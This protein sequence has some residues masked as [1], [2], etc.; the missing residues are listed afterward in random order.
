MGV[1]V[2]RQHA[3]AENILD[4]TQGAAGRRVIGIGSAARP[5]RAIDHPV[6][7]DNRISDFGEKFVLLRYQSIVSAL[8]AGRSAV[9]A[10]LPES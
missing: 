4:E 3:L 8:R 7:A 10:M 2:K 9:S 5:E 1:G 6:V